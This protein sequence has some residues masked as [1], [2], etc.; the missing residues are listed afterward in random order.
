MFQLKICAIKIIYKKYMNDSDR[1][2]SK[3]IQK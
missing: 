2:L 1:Q 3:L